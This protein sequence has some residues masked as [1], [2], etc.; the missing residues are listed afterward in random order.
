MTPLG[1]DG[2]VKPQALTSQ[3]AIAMMKRTAAWVF[4]G[5]GCHLELTASEGI[6]YGAIQDPATEA[7]LVFSLGGPNRG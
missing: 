1:A 3:V 2:T 4:K 6:I 5:L 7:C